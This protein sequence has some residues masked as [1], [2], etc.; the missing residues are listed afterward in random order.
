MTRAITGHLRRA[1]S[2]AVALDRPWHRPGAVRYALAR[3][4]GMVRPPVEV[5]EPDPDSL[6]WGPDHQSRLLVPVVS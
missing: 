4:R 3:L 6:H 2:D 1:P 5:H